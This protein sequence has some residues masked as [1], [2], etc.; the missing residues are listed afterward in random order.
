MNLILIGNDIDNI[1]L[2]V[3]KGN[4]NYLVLNQSPYV[5]GKDFAKFIDNKEV[6][7]STTSERCKFFRIYD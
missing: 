7:V 4:T 6:I 2:D 3:W 5:W 1:A